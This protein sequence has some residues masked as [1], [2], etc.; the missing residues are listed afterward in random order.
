MR[1]RRKV[2]ALGGVALALLGT[3]GMAVAADA[4][5]G[6]PK[7]TPDAPLT[8]DW[9]GLYFGAQTGFSRGFSSAN[10]GSASGVFGYNRFG[11]MI[12]GIQVGYNHLLPSNILLG[13][14]SDLSS[15]NTLES[16]STISALSSGPN[17][18]TERMDFLATARG[19][20]GYVLNP[21][22][23]YGTAGFAWA[24]RR[25]LDD[26]PFG[27]ERKV[28]RIS[29]GAAIGGGAEYA[30]SRRWALRLEYLYDRFSTAGVTFGP[31]AHY[32][33][34][35]D[36]QMWRL[37]LNSKVGWN[38]AGSKASSDS[39]TDANW[40][41]HGQTTYIQQ[42]YPP[43]HA[44]YSG[45]NSLAPWP[46]TRETLTASAFLGLRAWAGGE[47]YYTAELLQG[48][49]L[50][51]TV[52]LGGFSNGDAQKSAFSY[53]NYSKS[54]L[55]VRQTV[56]FGGQQETLESAPN[57]LSEK[58]DVSRL[59]VQAGLFPVADL[60]DGNAYARDSR[61]GFMN[62]AI[63]AAGAFDYAAD[64]VGLGYGTTAE[65]NQRNWALRAGYFLMDA[66]SNSS[67]FDMQWFRR[68]EYL[69]E[70]ETRYDLLSHPGK[71][72]TIG[73]VNSGFMG[74]YREALDNS[75]LNLDI[76]QT[77]RGRIK[78]GYVLNLEQSL[79][80]D[81]GL[82]AR[83]SWNDGKTEI[84]SF[85]DIDA[86]FS[87]GVSIKGT[88]WNRPDDNIGMA[89]AV[90]ALSADHRDFTAAGGLGILIG[91]GKL[92]YRP[93]QIL[94]VYYAYAVTKALALTID[95]QFIA[96]PAYNADRGPLSIFSGR[97]HAEF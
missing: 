3:A 24:Q 66:Q 92:N 64:R 96:N 47:L 4:G 17:V 26:T 79:T 69:V 36:F 31:G 12:G 58:V 88:S 40:E 73:W 39:T 7:Q 1:S 70:L 44:P 21:W 89:G 95:Y 33:S 85:T 78:Y 8:Y 77:R 10:F 84:M 14:E 49:G 48:F 68:G 37:G 94:E 19:R 67:N 91:D 71:L 2:V 87:G 65:L 22:M 41:L 9:S 74:S 57:Q 13:L 29:P 63:W 25:F 46:Q 90:N 82:F 38:D 23:I 50:S 75:A 15:P 11:G 97:V 27:D 53:P 34:Q 55:F 51:G 86:S 32:S 43:F 6:S 81:L 35:M 83:W 20:V 80:D 93:E 62:W 56:G 59:T 30:F 61:S 72:R 52:G 60:F 76:V 16:N 28:L 45:A 54:R 42:G 5:R 18:V